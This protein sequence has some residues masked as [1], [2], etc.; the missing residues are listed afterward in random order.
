M[1]QIVFHKGVILQISLNGIEFHHRF[2]GHSHYSLV[3]ERSVWQGAFTSVGTASLKYISPLRGY[4]NGGDEPDRTKEMPMVGKYKGKQGML[5]EVFDD[6]IVLDRRSFS[7]QNPVKLGP[8][9]VIPLPYAAP[10][11]FSFAIRRKKM[12]R[13]I[14]SS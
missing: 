9:W 11:P 10:G 2:S 5:M 8:D 13:C 4:E 6:R 7:T 1:L 12:Q 3:D 14:L